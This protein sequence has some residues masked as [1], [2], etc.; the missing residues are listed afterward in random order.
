MEEYITALPEDD[1]AL[2]KE[3]SREIKKIEDI[4]ERK[5]Y[6]TKLAILKEKARVAWKKQERGR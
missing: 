3:L 4:E 2:Y 6:I 5:N 1:Q